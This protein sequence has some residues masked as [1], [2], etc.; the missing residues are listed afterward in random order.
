[1]APLR[2]ELG[3]SKI[4]LDGEKNLSNMKGGIKPEKSLKSKYFYM[5]L[6]NFK[7]SHLAEA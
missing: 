3:K 6:P 4:C 7:I 1:M 5:Q 2:Y